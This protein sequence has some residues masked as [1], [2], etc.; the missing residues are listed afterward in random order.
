MEIDKHKHSL[1][2]NINESKQKMIDELKSICASI[3][4]TEV[5]LHEK[6]KYGYEELDELKKEFCNMIETYNHIIKSSSID[7]TSNQINN[8]ALV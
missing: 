6:I 3:D 4:K 7:F 1:M 5:L 2:N 8:Q